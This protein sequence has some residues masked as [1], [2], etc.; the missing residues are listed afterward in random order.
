MYFCS[1]AGNFCMIGDDLVNSYHLLLC[2][3]DLVFGNALLCSNRKDL[4]NLAFKGEPRMCPHAPPGMSSSLSADVLL[5]QVSQPSTE[6]MLL[7]FLQT[8]LLRVFW[9]DSVSC[10]TGWWWRRKASS[11]TTSNRTFRNS[12]TNRYGH[13]TLTTTDINKQT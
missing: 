4:I 13:M 3:L 12:S 5:W 11:S 7:T 8:R 1:P 6:L 10:T 9:S 2:C